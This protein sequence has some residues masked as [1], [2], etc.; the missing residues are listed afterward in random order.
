MPATALVMDPTA[1]MLTKLKSTD[2]IE[3]WESLT[4]W[5]QGPALL[6][7]KGF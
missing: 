3:F 5:D 1:Q 4:H 6:T 2:P 7:L